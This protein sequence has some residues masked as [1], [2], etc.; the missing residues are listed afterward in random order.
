[1]NLIG[2]T[3]RIATFIAIYVT[4]YLASSYM[5][6]ATTSLGLQRP[7][8]SEKNV[9]TLTGEDYSPERAWLITAVGGA[10]LVACVLFSAKYAD[11]VEDW[12]LRYPVCSFGKLYFNPWSDGIGVSPLHTLSLALAFVVCRMLAAAN[13]LSLYLGGVGPIG[14]LMKTVGSVTSPLMGFIIVGFSGFMAATVVLSPLAA[15]VIESWRDS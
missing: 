15:R 2:K 7:G 11:K 3:P 14:A 5:G 8:V 13:N 12:W 1:M 4:L 10:V 9:F 6:L